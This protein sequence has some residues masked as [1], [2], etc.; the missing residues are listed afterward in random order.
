MA[1]EHLKEVL[2]DFMSDARIQQEIIDAQANGL[3][4]MD[5]WGEAAERMQKIIEGRNTS[6]ITPDEFWSEEQVAI[7]KKNIDAVERLNEE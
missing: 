2:G 4:L 7:W 1:Q 3:T 6:D 5:V